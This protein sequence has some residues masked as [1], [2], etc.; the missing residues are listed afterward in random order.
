LLRAAEDYARRKGC[1]KLT[2]EVQDDNAAARNLYQRFGF[3]DFVF[4][5]S[6]PTRFLAKPLEG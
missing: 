5:D 2:L 6:A 4:G 1:C 3:A